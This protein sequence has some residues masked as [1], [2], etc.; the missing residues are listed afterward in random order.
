MM[1]DTGYINTAGTDWLPERYT[2]MET[3]GGREGGRDCK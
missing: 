3:G 2:G 1:M